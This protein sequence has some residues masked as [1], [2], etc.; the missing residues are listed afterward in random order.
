MPGT[1]TQLAAS[2]SL[3]DDYLYTD[4]PPVATS[5]LGRFSV[6]TNSGVDELVTV[7]SAG[8]LLH[9]W[10]DASSQSGWSQESIAVPAPVGIPTEPNI[11]S[12]VAFYDGPTLN[13][14]VYFEI[15]SEAQLPGYGALTWMQRTAATWSNIDF[16]AQPGLFNA[17]G[18][19]LS[20]GVYTDPAGIHYLYSVTDGGIGP[21]FYIVNYD[22]T[23]A[24][25]TTCNAFPALSL[26]YTVLPGDANSQFTIM[27][28]EN[29]SVF[30]QRA[31]I[32]ADGNFQWATPAP[33]SFDLNEG[34]LAT[35]NII[36]LPAIANYTGPASFLL[37]GNPNP[38]QTSSLYY[39]AGYDQPQPTQTLLNPAPGPA[40]IAQVAVG[41]DATSNY[42]LFATDIAAQSL[43]I[44]R[45]SSPGAFAPWVSLGDVLGA[46]ACPLSMSAGPEV[47]AVSIAT[48]INIV[49]YAQSL[50]SDP[51]QPYGM[52]YTN[53]I[54]GPVPSTTAPANVST[55]TAEITFQDEN[56]SAVSVPLV[57]VTA[58][59]A[60]SIIV[61]G[62][63]YNID[64]NTPAQLSPGATGQISIA[65]PAANL[66]APVLSLEIPS[67][68]VTSTVTSDQQMHN[69]LAGKDP[70][71]PVSTATLTSAG[72][73]DSSYSSTEADQI[74][75]A[76]TTAAS[77]MG[78]MATNTLAA[79]PVQHW[80]LT[81]AQQDQPVR[82][83]ILSLEE[84]QSHA[85]LGTSLSGI[86]GDIC[87]FFKKVAQKLVSVV[88]SIA[89]DVLN[90]AISIGDFVWNGIVKTVQEA[91]GLLE[92]I[93]AKVAAGV[94]DAYDAVKKAIDWLKMLFNW[95]DITN[96]QKVLASVINTSLTNLINS[97]GPDAEAWVTN[98]AA[99]LEDRVNAFFQN[100]RTQVDGLFG[101][102]NSL[103]NY[104][105]NTLG[106]SSYSSSYSQNAAQ[107]N[108]V[109][110]KVPKNTQVT[111][112]AAPNAPASFTNLLSS[113]TAKLGADFTTAYQQLVTLLKQQSA[114]PKNFINTA[115]D[116]LIDALQVLT[117]FIVN[118]AR[119]LVIAL[120]QCAADALVTLQDALNYVIDI[121]FLSW[122]FKN[123][124]DA[125]QDLTLLNLATLI[126]AL[127]ST[128]LYKI[129]FGRAPFTG[130]SVTVPW[131]Q[132]PWQ[133]SNPTGLLQRPTLSAEDA[134]TWDTVALILGVG[135][136]LFK[137]G[138]DIA[139]CI[140][141]WTDA[142]EFATLLSV[143]DALFNLAVQVGGIPYALIGNTNNITDG[144]TWVLWG[145]GFLPMFANIGFTFYTDIKGDARFNEESGYPVMI[146][147][148]GALLTLGIIQSVAQGISK[149]PVYNGWTYAGNILTPIPFLLTAFLYFKDDPDPDS[150][151]LFAAA[152]T[153]LTG[154]VDLAGVVVAA[155]S[156]WPTSS[157]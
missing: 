53:A 102:G 47:Y 140:A 50:T 124:I 118:I 130:P 100:W 131:P 80:S 144:D 147:A 60:T 58:D 26:T 120:M 6:V 17:L 112:G 96:T 78:A 126:I 99:A 68:N 137:I 1:V 91:A 38:D 98:E 81:F 107:C 106:G 155:G 44:L 51:T 15:A 153:G 86:W 39:I 92:V 42:I 123:V 62:I 129:A 21:S 27:W 59:R 69:R 148:G 31:S 125:G 149:E 122:L 82:F 76:I 57:N 65:M 115:I 75:T 142:E 117:D 139:T 133:P 128:I 34:T 127:P 143:V 41:L 136:G 10:P 5:V 7:D 24:Q 134:S 85:S 37:K 64:Q 101:K 73:I 40:G 135:V 55:Y 104:N 152:Y 94:T 114:S 25:W 103:N 11:L 89:N 93:F 154:V 95:T 45:Q 97:L 14:L 3:I 54:A 43:W 83:R 9:L 105:G 8:N 74:T 46:M 108:Y 49:H 141:A 157:S 20:A 79:H 71:F 48:G 22:A 56:Q 2:G 110:N 18:I 36:P 84:A 77:Q 109:K 35:G 119:D 32:D 132:L 138:A 16:G 88:V 87:H 4:T 72:L 29:Q 33:A 23:A 67:A 150:N 113:I 111:D 61:D 13:V 121:P 145:L 63:S 30:F 151:L 12:L 66:S 28:A 90:L 52:W 116:D 70:T 156:N 146:F 19:S